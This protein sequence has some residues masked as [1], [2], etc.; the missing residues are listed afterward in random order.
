MEGLFMKI[1][2]RM[3][4]RSFF[5]EMAAVSAA[6]MITEIAGAASD[7]GISILGPKAGYTPQ[8]P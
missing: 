5:S 4:R 2:Q 3:N 6:V 7:T 1:P 8:K